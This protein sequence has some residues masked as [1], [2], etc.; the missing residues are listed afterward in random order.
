M[1]KKK[2]N[3][4]KTTLNF[5]RN[6]RAATEQMTEEA[7]LEVYGISK[8]QALANMD[9]SITNPQQ[10]PRGFHRGFGLG[11]GSRPQGSLRSRAQEQVIKT[12]QR[13]PSAGRGCQ[14]RRR[15]RIWIHTNSSEHWQR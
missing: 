11:L 14:T 7:C 9:S 1:T 8:A 3:E 5:L 2:L 15:I 4:I 6:G 12:E 13:S 10:R